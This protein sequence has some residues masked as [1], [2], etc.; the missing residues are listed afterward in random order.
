MPAVLFKIKILLK[1]IS[2]L[3]MCAMNMS[4]VGG[5]GVAWGFGHLLW[6]WQLTFK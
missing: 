1:V 4:P 5:D 2:L 6:Q 3:F